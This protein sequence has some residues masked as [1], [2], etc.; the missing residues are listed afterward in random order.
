MSK[1]DTNI[2]TLEPDLGAENL[3]EDINEDL[4]LLA[5]YMASLTPQQ[6]TI[7]VACAQNVFSEIT[8]TDTEIATKCSVDRKTV[9]RARQ[10]STWGTALTLLI[11][12]VV[13]GSTDKIVQRIA[14]ASEKDWRA[15][16]FLL[17]YTG[18]YVQRSQSENINVN[19]S[20]GGRVQ[21]IQ[22][23]TEELV[24]AMIDSGYSLDQF[25]QLYHRIKAEGYS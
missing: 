10:N 19:V 18:E 8:L 14:N 15:A 24:K 12:S 25:T 5:P 2:A 3:P 16:K 22:A 7:L 9:Y 21:S 11:R 17:E 13:K 4:S 23:A 20:T 6:Q 1:T